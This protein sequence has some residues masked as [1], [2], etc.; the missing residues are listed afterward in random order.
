MAHLHDICDDDYDDDDDDGDDDDTAA[1]SLKLRAP[2]AQYHGV[3]PIRS[4]FLHGHLFLPVCLHLILR[5]HLSPVTP[6]RAT[7]F[8][9][10]SFLQF[11]LSS[12]AA[13]KPLQL[14]QCLTAE[15]ATS[16]ERTKELRRINY[17]FE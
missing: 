4:F 1:V 11:P 3:M 14:I 2:I 8:E 12:C 17:L 7:D 6:P 16:A 9:S 5:V 13:A 15:H 10:P